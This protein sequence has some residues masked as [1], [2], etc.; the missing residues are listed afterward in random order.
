MSLFGNLLA[1]TAP[2]TSVEAKPVP[3]GVVLVNITNC[4]VRSNNTGWQGVS[5]EFTVQ[6]GPHKGRKVFHTFSVAM[7]PS[8]RLSKADADRMVQEGRA[9][10]VGILTAAG[11]PSPNA[12]DTAPIN[13]RGLG[14]KVVV[15]TNK[16]SGQQENAVVAWMKGSDVPPASAGGSPGFSAVGMGA[17][18]MSAQAPLSTGAVAGFSGFAAAAAS[19]TTNDAG[20]AKKDD[21]DDDIPF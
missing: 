3:P 15:R 18:A 6:A 7:Q 12:P 17:V 11:H 13:G 20:A 5:F 8:E 14:I 2:T 9:A 1:G 21:L 4:E 16:K 19:R 10:V